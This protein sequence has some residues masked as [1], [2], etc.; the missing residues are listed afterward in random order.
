M[1]IPRFVKIENHP[2]LVR[3]MQTKA[4]LNVNKE[5]Y[6]GFKRDR[7]NRHKI[8]ETV[9]EVETLKTDMEEIKK[10]LKELLTTKS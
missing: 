5:A 2:S 1:N 3:D 6:E 9:A 10:L 8:Q 7:A 4:I